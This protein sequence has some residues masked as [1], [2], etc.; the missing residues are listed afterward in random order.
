MPIHTPPIYPIGVIAGNPV[1]LK[2]ESEGT[3]YKKY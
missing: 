3:F 2:I 1:Y